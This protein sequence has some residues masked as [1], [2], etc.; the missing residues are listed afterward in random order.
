M[1]SSGACRERNIGPIVD[2]HRNSERRDQSAGEIYEL[3]GSR[4]LEAKLDGG[5]A[6]T[7]RG[8]GEADDVAT[9]EQTVV[10]HEHE[11]A[12]FGYI[13]FHVRSYPP[14]SGHPRRNHCHPKRRGR[15]PLR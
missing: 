2:E 13:R 10:S 9:L 15:N 11:A 5:N 1:Y 4:G 7:L 3:A 8:A 12:P 6:A 14:A